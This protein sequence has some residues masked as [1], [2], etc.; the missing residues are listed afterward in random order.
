[1]KKERVTVD[2]VEALEKTIA[3]VREAQKI[4]ATYTQEQVDKIFL[5]AASAEWKSVEIRRGPLVIRASGNPAINGIELIREE[6]K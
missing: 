2:N 4:F 3:E 5:A 6:T 1:M